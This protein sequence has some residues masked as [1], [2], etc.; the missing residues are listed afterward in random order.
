MAGD[1]G[2]L[3]A[4]LNSELF[5]KVKVGSS[6]DTYKKFDKFMRKFLFNGRVSPISTR[7]KRDTTSKHLNIL[8]K[9]FTKLWLD[10]LTVFIMGH[11]GTL[12]L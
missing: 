10:E 7:I 2:E 12:A 9:Y 3:I 1:Q 5:L 6:D 4:T 8:I 11:R